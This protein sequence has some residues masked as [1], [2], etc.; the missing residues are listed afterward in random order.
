MNKVIV[1]V[2]AACLMAGCA[3]VIGL[4]KYHPRT[5]T[6]DSSDAGDGGSDADG[7]D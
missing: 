6:D 3:N 7:S 4:D 5:Q 2:V 1:M